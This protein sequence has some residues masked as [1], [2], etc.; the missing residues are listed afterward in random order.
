MTAAPS[1]ALDPGA[2]LAERR[3]RLP[4]GRVLRAI[5]AGDAAGPAVVFEAGLGAPA[6]SWV[7]TQ[8]QVAA[9]ARTISYDRAGFGGSD[10]DAAPRTLGRLATDLA[11]M[12]DALGETAPV[13]LVGHSWGGPIL[14]AFAAAHPVRVAGLVLVDASTAE[15]LPPRI[16]KLA[17]LSYTVMG[18]LLRLGLRRV[19]WRVNVPHGFSPQ[20]AAQD[21]ALI[22]RDLLS[23]RA[24][25]AA[26][27]EAV[28]LL[29]A[30]P[31]LARLQAQGTPPVP[32]VCVNAGRVD[33]GMTTLRPLLN[34]TSQQLMERAAD[35][36]LVIVE[37]AGHLVPQEQPDAVRD[38]IVAVLER[39]RMAQS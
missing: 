38:E 3:V 15:T 20:I 18:F 8:R 21:V 24:M 4:D 16:T 39:A 26:R 11:G 6:S 5:T 17:P 30:L 2:G 36:R 7:H 25:A 19:V 10:P 12:L 32:T 37:E 22:E 35:G 14:R 1:L 33:P 29:G 34:R 27:R 23:P 13:V 28:Q 9:H 31:E